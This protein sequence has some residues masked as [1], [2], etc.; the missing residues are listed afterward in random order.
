MDRRRWTRWLKSGLG[1]GRALLAVTQAGGAADG[2]DEQVEGGPKGDYGEEEGHRLNP[3][4]RLL[5]G[6][7]ENSRVR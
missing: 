3:F 5:T 2:Q 6:F 1:S 4:Y 7:V